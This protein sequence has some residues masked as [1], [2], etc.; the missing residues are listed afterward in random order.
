MSKF[1][2]SCI[3]VPGTDVKLSKINPADRQC[4][5]KGKKSALVQIE[6]Y[7]AEIESMQELL[8]AGHRHRVLIVLQGIDTAGKDGTIKHVF[9]GV[10]PQG[11]KVAS[12]KKPTP[13][14]LDH[15][16]LWRIHPHTPGKGEIVIFNRSHYEDVI[17]TKVHKLVPHDILKDRYDHINNFEEMLADEGVTIIKFFLYIDN[18]EQKKRL[19]E[20][21][22]MPE[23]QWKLS[24][25][26][27]PER[28]LWDDYVKAYEDVLS[29][30]STKRAPWFI[31]PSNRKW[32]RNLAISSL[33][34]ETLKNLHMEM[35]KPSFDVSKLV[36]E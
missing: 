32:Y 23:K 9:D 11:V 28:K 8:Y 33:M 24:E 7:R 19:L 14:E 6:K 35:P 12:F 1:S 13:L 22:Q 18:E 5:K 21:Q 10:N 30:T 2:K 3:V 34:H 17:V 25:S 36:I 31:I 27:V 29:K 16:F 4:F 15:D 26:D 20:R